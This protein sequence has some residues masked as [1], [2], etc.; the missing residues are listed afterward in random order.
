MS[1]PWLS[2]ASSNP[3]PTDECIRVP[4]PIRDTSTNHPRPVVFWVPKD[5]PMCGS[6]KTRC[7]GKNRKGGEYRLCRGCGVRY[8]AISVRQ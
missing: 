6:R 2:G 5:C 8:D 4:P 3:W 7:V 1:K